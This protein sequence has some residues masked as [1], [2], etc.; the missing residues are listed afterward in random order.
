M[1]RLVSNKFKYVSISMMVFIF[2][3]SLWV[4]VELFMVLGDVILCGIPVFVVT[5]IVMQKKYLR[6]GDYS[7]EKTRL[8]MIEM[9]LYPLSLGLIVTLSFL[10]PR[11]MIITSLALLGVI[12]DL[13]IRN[14]IYY[15][16]EE[17]VF[18]GKV[19]NRNQCKIDK[20]GYGI[21]SYRVSTQD[22]DVTIPLGEEGLKI[23]KSLLNQ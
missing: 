20:G 13:R 22:D 1:K 23:M 4:N 14:R 11:I 2:F 7:L 12:L 6:N 21:F 5:M 18:Y 17:V 16:D 19:F 9:I 15:N 3:V 8:E 10:N